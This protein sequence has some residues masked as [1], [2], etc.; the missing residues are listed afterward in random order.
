MGG[1]GGEGGDKKV[2]KGPKPGI[3]SNGENAEPPLT[4]VKITKR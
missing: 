2:N 1:E 3:S 4:D